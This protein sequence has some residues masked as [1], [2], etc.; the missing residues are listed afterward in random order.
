MNISDLFALMG[1]F[2]MLPI[3]IIL[4]LGILFVCGWTDAPN[5]VSTVVGTRC[6]KPRH[7]I[8]MSAIF[9]FAGMMS[10]FFISTATASSIMSLVDFG[11]SYTVALNAMSAAMIAVISWGAFAT[12]FGIPSSQSHSLIA[13]II[14]AG[15]AGL[16]LGYDTKPDFSANGTFSWTLY[17]LVLSLVFG[18]VVGFLVNKLIVLIC[19]KMQKHKT[20]KFFRYAEVASC[21]GLSYVHGAQDGLK[22]LGVIFICISL[23][24]KAGGMSYDFTNRDT[25][26]SL[27]WIALI[28]AVA[29]AGGT[30]I[31]SNKMIKKVGMSMVSLRQYEG[32]ATDFTS[33]IGVLISTL[34][35]IPV[36]TSQVKT[37]SVLGVGASKNIK[38]INWKSFRTMVINWLCTFPGCGLVGYLLALLFITVIK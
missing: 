17:G 18:F 37:C 12:F 5:T 29:L 8:I 38:K 26:N 24:G 20:K 28:C 22:F 36:S 10:M 4:T 15:L 25:L 34:L 33:A 23:A 3:S 35:G 19:H 13:G 27:W 7:A 21:A 32:F 16:T 14:G 11:T 6:M 1:Q 31:G 9:N 30:L 2:P